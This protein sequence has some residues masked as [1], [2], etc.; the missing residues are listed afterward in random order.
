MLYKG[1]TM[2]WAVCKE[3]H[4]DGVSEH[5]HMAV[6]L[7]AAQCWLGALQV[8]RSKNN[9][10]ANFSSG[11]CGYVAAYMYVCKNKAV[12]EVLHSKGHTNLEILGS[13]CTSHR[14]NHQNHRGNQKSQRSDWHRSVQVFSSKQNK[15]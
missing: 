5:Y 15:N 8:L 2:G 14:A 13:P 4:S 11:H 9:I 3:N 6:K 1:N 10:V 7:S 12:E